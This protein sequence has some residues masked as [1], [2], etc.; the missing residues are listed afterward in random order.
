MMK[1]FNK[2]VVMMVFA[3][4]L[5]SCE[6]DQGLDNAQD[7][8]AMEAAESEA[9]M[10][11]AVEEIDEIAYFSSEYFADNGRV[12][13]DEMSP[14]FC[15]ERIHDKENKTIIVNYG[16]EGCNDW[17]GRSRRG[18]IIIRYTDHLYVPGAVLS[19]TFEN[20][21]FRGVKIDGQRIIKNISESF[22]DNLMFD[23]TFEGTFTWDDGSVSTRR[24]HWVVERIRTPNPINDEK[25]VDGEAS[26]TTKN[27]VD[28]KVEITETIVFKRSCGP[29]HVFIPVQGVKVITWRGLEKIIDY[30]DGECDRIV[31]ITFNGTTEEVELRGRFKHKK[32]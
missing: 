32:G 19:I 20:F 8:E 18:K 13:D 3:G 23:I 31:T 16:D 5:F 10:D 21:Y 14:I 9:A 2:Y 15:A 25:H 27:G 22:D 12:A 6:Q 4:F 11:E 1:R 17:H 29:F 30:G 28:Y 26:G 7:A 24:S